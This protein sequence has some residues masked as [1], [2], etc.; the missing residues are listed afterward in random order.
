MSAW[1]GCLDT[2][3]IINCLASNSKHRF[4]SFAQ[5]PRIT[6]SYLFEGGVRFGRDAGSPADP[7]HKVE[8]VGVKG[9]L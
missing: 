2:L 5:N 9:S 3:L 4:L 8:V 6:N 1:P 7:Y